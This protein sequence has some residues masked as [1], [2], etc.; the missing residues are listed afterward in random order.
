MIYES[1]TYVKLFNRQ[2]TSH[3]NIE[4]HKNN[5]IDVINSIK[6]CKINKANRGYWAGRARI[7]LIKTYYGIK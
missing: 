2:F 3:K 7:E 1:P 6:M 5:V 4:C